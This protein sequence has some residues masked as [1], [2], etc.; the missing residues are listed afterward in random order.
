MLLENGAYNRDWAQ[1]HMM[2]EQT[3]Q[4]GIDLQAKVVFPIHW[5]KFD[6][7]YHKWDEPILRFS[8]EA[9]HQKLAY[10]TP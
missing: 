8:K 1:I 5:S 10:T 2:P 3:V 6:L 9:R 4:A 7:S